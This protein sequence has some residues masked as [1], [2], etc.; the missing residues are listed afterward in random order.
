[1]LDHVAKEFVELK[2]KNMNGV[3]GVLLTGSA[4]LGYQDASSGVDLQ[5]IAAKN[6]CR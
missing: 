2:F 5:I 3:L 6:F 1:M 4:P